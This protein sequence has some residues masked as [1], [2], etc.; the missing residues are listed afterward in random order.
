MHPELSFLHASL[1]CEDRER[2]AAEQRLAR[3]AA[4][5]PRER[6][7][8][9]ARLLAARQQAGFRLVEIGLYLAASPGPRPRSR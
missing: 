2:E 9:R 6:L 8:V 7:P 1:L 4:R 3:L 5:R